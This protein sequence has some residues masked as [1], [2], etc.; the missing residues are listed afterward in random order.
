MSMA[1]KV[2]FATE[3]SKQ[4]VI[5]HQAISI[6]GVQC[7]VRGGGPQAQN[8]LIYNYPVEGCEESICRVLGA[9]GDIE[10]ISFR[11]WLHLTDVSDGVCVVRM[12]CCLAIPRILSIA[13]VNVKVLMLVKSKYVIC[14]KH[15]VT[16]RELVPFAISAFSVGLRAIS[17]VT[18]LSGLAIATVM[19][20]WM[21]QTPPLQRLLAVLLPVTMHP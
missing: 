8:V 7:A 20:L 14:V 18:A 17:H 6:S 4:E 15:L 3:A 13:E 12:F 10:R 21:Q 2:T 5:N 19:P 16:L 1:A 11:H 9:Y